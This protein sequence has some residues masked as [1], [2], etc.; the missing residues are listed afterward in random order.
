MGGGGSATAWACPSLKVAAANYCSARLKAIG[1]GGCEMVRNR[2]L[3]GDLC[4][5]TELHCGVMMRGPCGERE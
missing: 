1:N 3:A 2:Q 4:T 5:D